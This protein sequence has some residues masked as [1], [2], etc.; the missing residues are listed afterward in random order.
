VFGVGITIGTLGLIASLPI[1]ASSTPFA[2]GA[3]LVVSEVVFGRTMVVTRQIARSVDDSRG[4]SLPQLVN[5]F[6]RAI[7]AVGF[8]LFDQSSLGLWVGLHLGVEVIAALS[9]IIVVKR[10]GGFPNAVPDRP[11]LAY[12]R[13]GLLYSFNGSAI[14]IKNDADKAMLSGF[15]F[16][17]AAGAYAMAYRVIQAAIQPLNALLNAT[18][19]KFFGVGER[20]PQ[21]IP[22]MAA[23]YTAVSG[24]FA[25]L[26][27]GALWLAT[28]LLT[29][30]LNEGEI[31]PSVI[32]RALVALPI[33]IAGQQYAA[34]GL[35]A[36]GRQLWVT[37]ILLGAAALNLAMNFVLIPRYSWQG[38][39]VA[40]LASDLLVAVFLW[41]ALL[42]TKPLT[43]NYPERAL[44]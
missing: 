14:G 9:G 2:I 16:I 35:T 41:V 31:D 8:V 4:A 32:V 5:R 22:G 20:N 7:A 30:L 19:T 11:S 6:G 17:E 18:I 23:R 25:V 12:A 43:G 44:D 15:G 13:E 3:T 27:A 38:A 33:L 37:R 21:K 28:P 42:R 40:T 36:T 26:C 29:R 34:R 1:L 24:A 39:V 10:L